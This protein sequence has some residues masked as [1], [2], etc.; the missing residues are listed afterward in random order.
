MD[1]NTP[2]TLKLALYFMAPLLS[3]VFMMLGS[4]F[5]ATFLSLFLEQ[6]GHSTNKIGFIYS[7]YCLGMLLGSFQM[8]KVIR[9][10]GHV[11]ALAVFGSI[12]SSAILIQGI[13]D[14]FMIW[15][16]MR[17]LHGLSIAAIYVV[18]ESWLLQHSTLAVRGI[19][20]SLYMVAIYVSQS[21]SQQ[22]LKVIDL[23]E[24][25]PF[26]IGAIFTSLSI[27]PVGLSTK[28]IVLPS[29]K[30]GSI[31]FIAIIKAA[32]LGVVGCLVSG[33]ILSA[34][35]SFFPVF[36]LHKNILASN[37]MT[38]TIAGAVLLQWPLGKLS[39]YF[40]RRKTLMAVVFAGLASTLLT[41]VYTGSCVGVVMTLCFFMGG[42]TFAIYPLS[43][44][45]VC[46]CV[47]P[48]DLTKVAALLLAV[49][50]FGSIIGPMIAAAI[51]DLF[52]LHGLFMY[53]SF[54]LFL[55]DLLGIYVVLKGPATVIN[56][57][58]VFMP[59][60]KVTPVAKTQDLLLDHK[61]SDP[62]E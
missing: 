24:Q 2:N 55:L 14:H 47:D 35:Y 57:Q 9:R 17:F 23:Q 48:D 11:Q 6:H 8:E 31:P 52:T 62:A 33:F 51:I 34:I 19:V 29:E 50:G 10:I 12:A 46:D 7:A 26:L 44:T 45:H 41:F 39:D 49:Y 21:A 60:P 37:L 13:S 22:F 27:I 1:K 5:F 56:D 36:A 42:F 43:A 25:A 32:P 38:V 58:N 3:V 53:F 4:G 15:L 28:R 61:P 59:R 18:I 20:M 16:I 54:L 30:R 40:E